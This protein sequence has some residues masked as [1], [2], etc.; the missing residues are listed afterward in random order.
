MFRLYQQIQTFSNLR[1]ATCCTKMIMICFPLWQILSK[2]GIYLLWFVFFFLKNMD[3]SFLLW[4]REL[5][6][7]RYCCSRFFSV[8]AWKWCMQ[9]S[10]GV[11]FLIRIWLWSIRLQKSFLWGNRIQNIFRK[12]FS[13]T[14]SESGKFQFKCSN[15]LLWPQESPMIFLYA[16]YYFPYSYAA[17]PIPLRQNI[18]ELILNALYNQIWI[19]NS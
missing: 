11:S 2:T 16:K 13:N 14:W 19:G 18:K 9:R 8:V 5:S 1:F 3:I 7:V 10:C 4:S 17:K 15:Q 6:C 12:F